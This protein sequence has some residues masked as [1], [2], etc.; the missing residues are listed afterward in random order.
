MSNY[1]TSVLVYRLVD[2]QKQ[3]KILRLHEY[4][5]QLLFLHP[6]RWSPVYSRFWSPWDAF[7]L[8]PHWHWLSAIHVCLHSLLLLPVVGT[9]YPNTSLLHP[10]C[11]FSEIA[12][13]L[14]SSGVPSSDFHHIFY[15]ACTLPVVIFG[16]LNH[17]FYLLTYYLLTCWQITATHPACHTVYTSESLLLLATWTG[18]SVQSLSQPIPVVIIWCI[19][20]VYSGLNVSCS[21]CC[22]LLLQ[23]IEFT[24]PFMWYLNDFI[25]TEHMYCIVALLFKFIL[26]VLLLIPWCFWHISWVAGRVSDAV[27]GALGDLD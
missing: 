7:A 2:S 14:S 13:R 4:T 15:S 19:Y 1:V 18:Y 12:S 3:Q 25:F 16:H 6:C 10:L 11:V 5:A 9:V 22:H 26:V 24:M 20:H 21:H 17:S 23:S 8:L 27:A